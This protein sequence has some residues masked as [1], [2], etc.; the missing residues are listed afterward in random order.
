MK[1]RKEWEDSVKDEVVQH[2]QTSAPGPNTDEKP[3]HVRVPQ[4]TT[5]SP[6]NKKPQ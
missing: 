4:R 1:P 2:S 3:V 6:D 5:K